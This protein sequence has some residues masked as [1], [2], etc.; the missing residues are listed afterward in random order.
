M[1]HG[2]KDNSSYDTDHNSPLIITI[3]TFFQ[4]QGPNNAFYLLRPDRTGMNQLVVKNARLTREVSFHFSESYIWP[5]HHTT[6]KTSTARV[7]ISSQ[8][9]LALPESINCLFYN[10]LLLL[11]IGV[12]SVTDITTQFTKCKNMHT[13]AVQIKIIY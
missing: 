7:S 9:R 13:I 4:G 12:R 2:I 3:N 6:H 8:F 11:A 5:E 10:L 1:Q